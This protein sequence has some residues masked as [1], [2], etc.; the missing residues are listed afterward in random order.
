ML[1]SDTR[2]ALAVLHDAIAAAL[3]WSFAYLLRFNFELPPMPDHEEGLLT[4][5]KHD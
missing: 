1:N 5:Q 2:T 3:A 4:D